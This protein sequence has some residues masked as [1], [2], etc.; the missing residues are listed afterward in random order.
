MLSV[1]WLLTNTSEQTFSVDWVDKSW[2]SYVALAWTGF[3]WR[4][5]NAHENFIFSSTILFASFDESRAQALC[6]QFTQISHV[7]QSIVFHFE[8]SFGGSSLQQPKQSFSSGVFD[9]ACSPF[10]SFFAAFLLV[11]IRLRIVRFTGKYT[12]ASPRGWNLTIWMWVK[13]SISSWVKTLYARY[14][15]I[16]FLTCSFWL[17]VY[18]MDQSVAICFYDV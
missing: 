4:T 8:I 14:L 5:Q 7:S 15:I 11:S 17:T 10:F 2:S 12:I 6:H 16:T 18:D 13:V 9:V 3:N 1:I